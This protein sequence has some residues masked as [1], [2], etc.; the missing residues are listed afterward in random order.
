MSAV[1]CVTMWDPHFLNWKSLGDGWGMTLTQLYTC[2]AVC[3][4]GVLIFIYI[5]VVNVSCVFMS[6]KCMYGNSQ[7]S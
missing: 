1:I 6:D 4:T 5:Y 7:V 3:V 2:A